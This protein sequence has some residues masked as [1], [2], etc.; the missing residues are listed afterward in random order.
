MK[1][2]EFS[3]RELDRKWIGIESKKFCK[4]IAKKIKMRKLVC[5]IFGYFYIDKENGLSLRVLG[6]IEKDGRN[7]LYLDN[8]LIFD[9]EKVVDYE[10]V[11]KFEIELLDED[12]VKCIEGSTVIEN[13]L[14]EIIDGLLERYPE[15]IDFQEIYDIIDDIKNKIID[16]E[17]LS[18]IKKQMISEQMEAEDNLISLIEIVN[19]K[20]FYQNKI[21]SN[22]KK[23][24]KINNVTEEDIIEVAKSLLLD[25][26]VLVGKE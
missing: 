3:F 25:T 19:Q 15:N 26:I 2:C 20:Y 4:K 1:V 5:P 18:A 23:I 16:K 14:D 21:I 7:K 10:F 6:N 17:L 11:S 13:K 12:V 9:E 8:D 24:D 22:Q